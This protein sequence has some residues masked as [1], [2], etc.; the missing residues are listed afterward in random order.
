MYEMQIT[1]T[2]AIVRELHKTRSDKYNLHQK[3][4]LCGISSGKGLFLTY[5][6]SNKEGLS[7]ST[8]MTIRHQKIF[9]VTRFLINEAM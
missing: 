4:F 5:R 8:A 1:A 7:L 3:F 6:N 2:L 9:S